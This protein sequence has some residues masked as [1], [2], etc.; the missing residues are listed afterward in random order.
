MHVVCVCVNWFFGWYR[1]DKWKINLWCRA[2]FV[3]F[4][5][6]TSIL[7]DY[8]CALSAFLSAFVTSIFLYFKVIQKS[9][10]LVFWKAATAWSA[11]IENGWWHGINNFD[12]NIAAAVIVTVTWFRVCK[13]L[14][15]DG[16]YVDVPACLPACMSVFV[17][18]SFA[19][20]LECMNRNHV[21]IEERHSTV[22]ATDRRTDE[23]NTRAAM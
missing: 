21:C 15:V 18:L 1:I 22:K 10:R 5:I 11:F 3:W 8:F 16:C 2:H 23:P 20:E 7:M 4:K 14:A 9:V 6:D 12:Y 19:I 17:L 13:L